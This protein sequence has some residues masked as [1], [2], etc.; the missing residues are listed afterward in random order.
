MT[1]INADTTVAQLVIEQP[2]LTRIFDKLGID[3][4]CGG[5]KPLREA[6]ETRGL[7][8]DTVVQ[9]LN[10]FAAAGGAEAD[11][12]DWSRAG[13]AELCDHIGQTHHR[14]LAEELPRL[15]Q[16]VNKVSRVHGGRHPHLHQV[17][18][19]FTELSEELLTHTQEEDAN[20][21]PLIRELEAGAEPAPE[22]VAALI[23]QMEADHDET[24][25]A[26]AMLRELTDGYTIPVDA[27]GSYRAMLSGLEE[28]ERDTHQHIHKENNILFPRAIEKGQALNA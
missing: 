16:L 6:C 10:A 20:V 26:L 2:A 8:P 28:L 15:G 4:C 7:D 5:K 3:Y 21:F 27:C 11:G 1:T 13:L 9:T 23:E 18:E 25:D 17:K 12:T 22:T 14:Y 24:G 19:V